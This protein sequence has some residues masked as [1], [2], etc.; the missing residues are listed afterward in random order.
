MFLV[1]YSELWLGFLILLGEARSL[2]RDQQLGSLSK[3][4]LQQQHSWDL[5]KPVADVQGLQGRK[6]FW[7]ADAAQNCSAS[8]VH[9]LG[10]LRASVAETQLHL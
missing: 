1:R 2:G 10:L 7:E 8:Q 3:W 5:D 6:I 4:F 9:S